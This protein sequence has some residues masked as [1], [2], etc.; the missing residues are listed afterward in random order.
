MDGW[1][2]GLIESDGFLLIDLV[3]FG[4]GWS[5]A[6]DFKIKCQWVFLVFSFGLFS[7]QNSPK[8]FQS[9]WMLRLAGCVAARSLRQTEKSPRSL[10]AWMVFGDACGILL[11]WF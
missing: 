8:L 2:D 6:S 10:E 4:C 7:H 9:C 5:W 1:I 11:R 3:W